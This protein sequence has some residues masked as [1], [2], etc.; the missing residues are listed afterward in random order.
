MLRRI[1]RTETRIQR[2][3][4]LD[5]DIVRITA[6][7]GVVFFLAL[8]AMTISVR[9][10]PI[11][12]TT[13]IIPTGNSV[14]NINLQ[15]AV[16]VTIEE[17]G[18]LFNNILDHIPV[19][20]FDFATATIVNY[21]LMEKADHSEPVIW[22]LSDSITTLE[23]NGTIRSHCEGLF[24]Q[25][26]YLRLDNSGTI[27]TE[28]FTVYWSDADDDLD[29]RTNGIEIVNRGLIT[30]NSETIGFFHDVPLG[31]TFRIENLESGQIHGGSDTIRGSHKL[32][33]LNLGRINS[34]DDVIIVPELR[35]ENSGEITGE[36]TALLFSRGTVFNS[37][38][39]QGREQH[40][41]N[42][43]LEDEQFPSNFLHLENA[44]PGEISGTNTGITG[45]EVHVVN[46][47]LIT[48][49]ENGIDADFGKIINSGI[50]DNRLG[51]SSLN[52]D[53]VIEFDRS[54][55]GDAEI[56]NAGVIRSQ[57]GGAGLAIDFR[58][59]WEFNPDLDME[60]P[61]YQGNDH[62]ELMPGNL[63]I[64]GIKFGLGDDRLTVR[65]GL[66]LRYTFDKLPE[67]LDVESGRYK[68]HINSDG[69]ATLLVLDENA[70]PDLT[71]SL[72]E[73]A[74]GISD[75]VSTHLNNRTLD[76]LQPVTNGAVIWADGFASYREKGA[77]GSRSPSAHKIGGLVS[78][79][80][81]AINTRTFAGAFI[82]AAAAE[83]RGD[84]TGIKETTDSLFFGLYG[85]TGWAQ[86]SLDLVLTAG[87]D[88]RNYE[89]QLLN[90]LKDSGYEDIRSQGEG[91][92]LAPEIGL[93]QVLPA[94][95]LEV[96]LRGRYAIQFNGDAHFAEDDLALNFKARDTHVAQVRAEIARPFQ[97]FGI[98][99]LRSWLTPY[100]GLE[101]R[102]ILKGG[103]QEI[104]VGNERG[105]LTSYDET[106]ETLGFAGL[107]FLAEAGTGFAFNAQLEGRTS[108][109]ENKTL[110]FTVGGTWNW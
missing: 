41:I 59:W 34:G 104:N 10:A 51:S 81:A 61:V 11:G 108:N 29:E 6:L 96:S 100:V 58:D 47:G 80:D 42:G 28:E 40:G 94:L 74:A 45:H 67:T 43:G 85:R 2:L 97:Y 31:L 78:G 21:G 103:M 109:R 49:G 62:L 25:G 4:R 15:G 24:M 23:N 46:A 48:G 66:N 60:V 69:T 7:V 57:F 95:G 87:Y 89:L 63:I 70:A 30:S 50:I 92:F 39:I 86:T 3:P 56:I 54:T 32:D 20:V 37:G 110:S 12:H 102:H 22:T 75:T 38:R 101:S 77:V 55:F 1:S 27:T 64:G 76:R 93:T 17:G 65:K 84:G 98:T 26:G 88:D 16:N 82:G 107:R 105:S 33:L 91:W 71:T 5:W 18:S 68:S 13:I 83:H 73:L 14:S 106:Q 53:A 79:L 35:V 72:V 99:G 36:R 44:V 8:I 52:D 90:N 19:L 9:A